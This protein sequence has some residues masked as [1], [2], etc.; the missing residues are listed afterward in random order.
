MNT[1]KTLDIKK[2]LHEMGNDIDIYRE[3]LE[4]FLEDTPRLINEIKEDFSNK[5][6]K[7]LERKSHSIKSTARTIGG[8]KLGDIAA[9]IEN[10]IKDE[11]CSSL[12][13]FI[14]QIEPEFQ[15]LLQALK[16]EGKNFN[17][18]V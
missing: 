4:V 2:A 8:M 5:A 1:N 6:F 9:T 3:I 10:L 11:D 17:F 13:P 15:L 12:E 16:I 14:N 7:N 18:S